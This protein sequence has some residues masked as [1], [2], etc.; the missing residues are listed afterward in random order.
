[1]RVLKLMRTPL[2]SVPNTI[3]KRAGMACTVL[4]P[5]ASCDKSAI[6]RAH[7][8]KRRKDASGVRIPVAH[9]SL[10]SSRNAAMHSVVESKSRIVSHFVA[11]L[12]YLYEHR[13]VVHTLSDISINAEHA[14]GRIIAAH[15]APVPY[16]LLLLFS[17]VNPQL[18]FPLLLRLCVCWRLDNPHVLNPQRLR[19]RRPLLQD[20]STK[21]TRTSAVLST[22]V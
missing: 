22:A 9:I 20:H 21:S 15:L 14:K 10:L 4:K 2:L 19:S 8:K 13:Y 6:V 7:V 17:V 12:P 1:M 11:S 18:F 5:K 3:A 16:V